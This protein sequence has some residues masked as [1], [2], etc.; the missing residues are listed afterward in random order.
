M[1][2]MYYIISLCHTHKNDSSITLWRPSNAGYCYSQGCAGKY[3]SIQEGYHDSEGNM[4][5]RC[6]EL[7]KLFI[8]MELDGEIKKVIPNHGLVHRALGV[9]MTK[10]GLKRI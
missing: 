6:I 5:V 1:E 9:K 8:E 4:P 10:K 7:D 2:D 3:D